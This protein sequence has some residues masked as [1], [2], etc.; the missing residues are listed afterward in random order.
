MQF[1]NPLFLFGLFAIA[2]PIIIH[3]FNFRKF[4]KVYF[5]NVEF[6]EELKQQ[7]QKQSQLKH[8]I[9]LLLRIL[10]ITAL[11]LAFAQPYIPV[12]ED[13]VIHDSQAQVSIFVDN[14]FSMEA[15]SQDG[16]LLD[17][18]IQDA[19]DISF[20]YKS[21][22]LFQLL[23]NDFEGKHQRYVSRDEFLEILDEVE[24]SSVTRLLSEVYNRQADLF[25]ESKPGNYTSYIISDFQNSISD[26]ENIEADSSIRLFLIPVEATDKNNLYIDSIWFSSPVQRMNQLVK[27]NVRIKN[28]SE[29]DFEKIPVKLMMNDQQRAIA[30]FDLNAGEEVVVEMPYTNNKTGIQ[31]GKLEITDFPITYDDAFYFTY[32]VKNEIPILSISKNEEGDEY[33]NSL[34]GKDSAFAFYQ[35]PENRLDYSSFNNFN[36]IILD[37]PDNISSGLSQGLSRFANNGG[38]VLVIPGTNIDFDNYMEF[39]LNLNSPYYTSVDTFQTKVSDINLQSQVFEDV[40]ESMPE[41]IDLPKVQKHYIIKRQTNSMFETLLQMQNGNIFLGAVPVGLGMVYIL[42]SPLDT[43]W[44]NFPK[45]AIFVPAL[46]KI[47]LL[48]NPGNK[49]FYTIGNNQNIVIRNTALNG[50]KVFK[51]VSMDQQFEVIPEFQNLNSQINISNNRISKAGNYTIDVAD[52]Q[53]AGVAFNYNRIE[54]N[55]DNLDSQA[56]EKRIKDTGL[57]N[58]SI[59]SSTERSLSTVI[60]QLNKGY[61]LWKT[62]IILVLVFLLGEVILLRFWK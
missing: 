14:S 6:I 54:S 41:N 53:L 56:L 59:I 44:S 55:L 43:E 28:A 50:D 23:T 5:T 47:A 21:S 32:E 38:S 62:F 35:L 58:T 13:E 22:D 7:T 16:I 31:F 27:L 57:Q 18:A 12:T 37:K 25:L 29:N 52:R 8:L 61:Q 20:A 24:I 34:F 48:S 51:I 11:V 46:Y 49:L 15:A 19:R 45:H 39:L 26:F 3:L 36:M 17:K 9:I 2:I 60:T 10:A 33:L 1:V 4:Q 30:S 42:A 40:F